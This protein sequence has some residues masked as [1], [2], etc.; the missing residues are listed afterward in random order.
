MHVYFEIHNNMDKFYNNYDE[1]KELDMKDY[2]SYGFIYI[3]H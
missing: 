1:E 3:K 2:I